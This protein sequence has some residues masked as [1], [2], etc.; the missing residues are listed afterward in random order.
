M[1][2]VATRL[3]RALLIFYPASFRQSFSAEMEEVFANRCADALSRGGAIH[4]CRVAASGIL[5]LLTT[6]SAEHMDDISGRRPTIR[7]YAAGVA[8]DAKYAIRTQLKRPALLLLLL[9]TL[10]LSIGGSTAIFSV[11]N[12]ALLRPLPFDHPERLVTLWELLPQ[13]TSFGASASIGVAPLNYFDWKTQNHV[14][15]Q[16]ALL[17]VASP[18]FKTGTGAE[19]LQAER[20]SSEFFELIGLRP[21][22]GRAFSEGDFR[23][24]APQI[25]IVSHDFWVQQLS[26][27][28]DVLGHPLKLDDQVVTVVGV[29]P[30]DLGLPSLWGRTTK[31]PDLWLPLRFTN[32]ELASRRYYAFRPIARLKPGITLDQADAE[33]AVIATRLAAQYPDTNAGM[34]IGIV[35][36]QE[37]L[38]QDLRPTLVLLF[39][40]TSFVLLIACVNVA[41]LLLVRTGA[42]RREMA[43]RSA[44]GATQAS[45]IRQLLTESL[46]LA[47]A[48]G[49]CGLLL[50]HWTIPAVI[51]LIPESSLMPRLSEVP[52]DLRVVAFTFGVSGLIALVFGLAPAIDASRTTV[53]DALKE[54]GRPG[55]LSQSRHRF[56]SVLVIS[57]VALALVL[58]V[59]A[60]V[61]VQSFRYLDRIDPGFPTDRL[62]TLEIPILK[63]KY[64]SD[65]SR[66]T[67]YRDLLQRLKALPGVESASATTE[68]P[69]ADIVDCVVEGRLPS[70]QSQIPQVVFRAISPEMFETLRMHMLQG[71]PFSEADT[72]QKPPVAIVSQRMA[73]SLWPGESPI[74]KRFKQESDPAGYWRTVIGIVGDIRR[75]TPDRALPEYY[76][77]YTQLAPWY[78]MKLI[79]RTGTEPMVLAPFIR[80]AIW[81]YDSDLSILDIQPVEQT[82]GQETWRHRLSAL[83]MTAFASIALLLAAA[84]IYG[85][86]TNA[87]AQRS[88][89]MGVRITL[90]ARPSDVRRMVIAKGMRLAVTGLIIGLAFAFGLARVLSTYLL[91][92]DPDNSNRLAM[93]RQIE[94]SSGLLYGISATDPITLATVSLVLLGFAFLACYLPARRATRVHPLTALRSD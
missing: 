51:S 19:Q 89:E 3:Y 46:L 11:A 60:G 34:G 90:G 62:L 12:A 18:N 30:G 73:R 45:I 29:M 78:A 81:S 71:R 35:P 10:T 25:A 58:L 36:L 93:A 42:R 8:A 37:Q 57:E 63:Y 94:Q 1:V 72:N 70:S 56:A 9:L 54:C 13:G 68:F 86:M 40:A 82:L 85:V 76:V 48:G 26:G 20:V 24:D 38:F 79:V 5:D 92:T 22:I 23:A 27:S 59:G 41:N 87:V 74:G 21:Q 53:N 67:L 2:Q 80:S 44:L 49:I 61:F 83:L 43:V 33:M 69:D 6:A 75:K 14:F 50:A 16:M 64:A 91:P 55:G 47:F 88:S 39:G 65:V 66:V 31:K 15:S 7:T 17:G 84:G 4:F 77:P 28:A 32:E 52:L